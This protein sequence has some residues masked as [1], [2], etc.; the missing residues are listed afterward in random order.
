MTE[1]INRQFLLKARPNGRVSR[2]N[3]DFVSTAVPTLRPGQALVR[4]LLLSLDPTNRIWMSDAD[5]YMPPVQIGEVMRGGGIGVVVESDNPKF[6]VG[7][8]VSGLVGWQ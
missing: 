1:K 2:A 3:F 7:D 6:K 8:H 5:Q 4:N